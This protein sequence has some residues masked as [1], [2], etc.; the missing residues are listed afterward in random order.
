MLAPKCSWGGDFRERFYSHYKKGS[1]SHLPSPREACAD[2]HRCKRA[3]AGLAGPGP[4]CQC[5]GGRRR[6]QWRLAAGRGRS[7][8][9]GLPLL[10][11]GY[12]AAPLPCPP[13]SLCRGAS[14]GAVREAFLGHSS[15]IICCR[16]WPRP[17]PIS[18]QLSPA[19]PALPDLATPSAGHPTLPSLPGVA[20]PGGWWPG[21]GSMVW[22]PWA[23]NPG[24]KISGFVQGSCK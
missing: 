17:S 14:V 10:F 22:R 7:G 18:G 2:Y 12:L 5:A 23:R 21:L 24:V 20:S 6:V 1:H 4:G 11:P 8:A 16:S 19:L 15:S 3:P 9:A 13:R